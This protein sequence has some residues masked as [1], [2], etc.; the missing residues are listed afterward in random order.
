MMKRFTGKNRNPGNQF[1]FFGGGAG[2]EKSEHKRKP[3]MQR[4]QLTPVQ[5]QAHC[6]PGGAAP[7]LPALVTA[8]PAPADAA[9]K[10]ST[11]RAYVSSIKDAVMK[12]GR[13]VSIDTARIRAAALAS[14]TTK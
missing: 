8:A 6:K 2:Q 13:V 4:I 12:G 9:A 5:R 10:P 14:K 7:A 3:Q 1:F 11:M